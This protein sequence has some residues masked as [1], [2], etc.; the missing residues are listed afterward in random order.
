[1]KLR[2]RLLETPPKVQPKLLPEIY[3]FVRDPPFFVFDPPSGCGNWGMSILQNGTLTRQNNDK[4]FINVSKM[5]V[6]QSRVFYV[7]KL[8][9][10]NSHVS[11]EISYQMRSNDG[12]FVTWLPTYFNRRE[13]DLDWAKGAYISYDDILLFVPRCIFPYNLNVML[14]TE[15]LFREYEIIHGSELVANYSSH[16]FEYISRTKS[17]FIFENELLAVTKWGTQ[18]NDAFRDG[19]AWKDFEM[20]WADLAGTVHEDFELFVVHTKNGDQLFAFAYL[21]GR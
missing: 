5:F 19:Q 14:I 21:A 18:F 13:R 12:K 11:N 16:R 20:E 17:I 6:H 8:S 2:I 1:M 4:N 3:V 10:P 9:Q 15:D 7:S